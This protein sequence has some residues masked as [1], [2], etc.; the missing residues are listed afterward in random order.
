M[1]SRSFF[2]KVFERK[3]GKDGETN[4]SSD[5]VA[6]LPPAASSSKSQVSIYGLRVL[7]EP[8]VSKEG[9]LITEYSKRVRKYQGYS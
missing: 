9:E 2:A 4:P 8:E 6:E 5:A 7:K 3:Q 1:K